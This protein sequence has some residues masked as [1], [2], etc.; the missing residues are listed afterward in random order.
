MNGQK[1]ALQKNNSMHAIMGN[2]KNE[3]A[4]E[5]EMLGIWSH[6]IRMINSCTATGKECKH[7]L[8]HLSLLQIKTERNEVNTSNTQLLTC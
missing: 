2:L 1:F 3:S 8:C 5:G 6:M 7:R 4:N